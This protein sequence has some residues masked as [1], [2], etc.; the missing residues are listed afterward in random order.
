MLFQKIFEFWQVS[1]Y[2]VI[3]LIQ[4]HLVARFYQTKPRMD[5]KDATGKTSLC[6]E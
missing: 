4:S 6:R 5:Y 3:Q 2:T 1:F